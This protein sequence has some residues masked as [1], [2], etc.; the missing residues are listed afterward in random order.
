MRTRSL[1]TF[2]CTNLF[3]RGANIEKFALVKGVFE[4]A[5][6]LIILLELPKLLFF[7]F[8]LLE[9]FLNVSKQLVDLTLFRFCGNVNETRL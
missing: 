3:K 8:Q 1:Y 7:F 4:T 9:A 2:V 6:F 5:P